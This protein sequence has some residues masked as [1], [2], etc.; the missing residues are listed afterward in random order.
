MGTTGGMRRERLGLF[1]QEHAWRYNRR[2]LNDEEKAD[3]S[4]DLLMKIG[5]TK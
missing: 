2:H 1:A 3:Q 5:G 4:V